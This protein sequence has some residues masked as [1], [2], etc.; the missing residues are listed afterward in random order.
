MDSLGQ[1]S[2]ADSK[3]TLSMQK[4][5]SSETFRIRSQNLFPKNI[6]YQ[7]KQYFLTVLSPYDQSK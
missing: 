7:N 5:S 2:K 3:E 1:L 6:T 4:Q